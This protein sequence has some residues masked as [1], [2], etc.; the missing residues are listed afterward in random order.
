[1]STG[2]GE[3]L[4][5]TFR[6][7][8]AAEAVAEN[9]D[10][11]AIS[12]ILDRFTEDAWRQVVLFL[13]AIL[14][15]RKSVVRELR[16]IK[17]QSHPLGLA[18][19]GVAIAEGADVPK[20]FTT[21]VVQDLC[22]EVLANANHG[23]CE[24]L[25]TSGDGG[26]R[27]RS[28][29]LPFIKASE[30]SQSIGAIIRGLT[31]LAFKYGGAGSSAVHD[32]FE[33]QAL[34]ALVLI[35][36]D[37]SAPLTLR[38]EIA[39]RLCSSSRSNTGTNELRTLLSAMA[40]NSTKWPQ[41]INILSK[42]TDANL[43]ASLSEQGLVTGSRWAQLLN[44][45]T[46]NVRPSLLNELEADPGIP[47]GDK[48]IVK[49]RQIVDPEKAIEALSSS[50]CPPELSKPLFDVLEKASDASAILR[51]ATEPGF[52]A[53]LH[54]RALRSLKAIKASPE[55]LAIAVRPDL[56][57]GLRYR[58]GLAAYG[59][60]LSPS[61]VSQLL[62]FF[63]SLGPRSSR[64]DILARRGFLNYRQGSFEESVSLFDKLFNARAGTSWELGIR[65]HA[66]EH[67]GRIDEAVEGYTTANQ[68]DAN[69]SFTR[70]RLAYILWTQ[71]K[72]DAA[73]QQ[74]DEA[75]FT[76][77]TVLD[78]FRPYGGDILR[79]VG[80]LNDAE[81]WLTTTL[82]KEPVHVDALTY[83]GRVAFDKGE[84]GS[85]VEYL[86]K[87]VGLNP[88]FRYAR[89]QLARV[90]RTAGRFA[91]AAAAFADLA[92]EATGES[93]YISSRAEALLRLGSFSEANS[94]IAD[95]RSSEPDQLYYLFLEAL[96]R[97][98]QGHRRAFHE[99]SYEALRHIVTGE[100]SSGPHLSIKALFYL[101]S[102]RLEQ[103][104]SFWIRSSGRG[105]ATS[106]A[107][108]RSHFLIA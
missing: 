104:T 50:V 16:H 4:H 80:K 13:I 62:S 32:L 37:P 85:A 29:L 67:L 43:L 48:L 27:A 45:L 69:N 91:D 76:A 100:S 15:E 89:I 34:D 73:A 2:Q 57:L 83:R 59:M 23:Y 77:Y 74:I 87:A 54:L 61:A 95:L 105:Y 21:E 86:R 93:E 90:L 5:P 96:S 40:A 55:L 39:E 52:A 44:S 75:G 8:L 58:A 3:W 56:P 84:F 66:L 41:L 79:E 81:T 68:R 103:P 106:C 7:F 12:D 9:G 71:G 102:G 63:N 107:S 65:A 42:S 92:A 18:F 60:P 26:S 19:V 1:M 35:A 70:C 98:F 14:S 78:W 6:E 22:A 99:L 28:A 97:C 51:V 94:I 38:A 17:P 53:S 64:P 33:L 108:T 101:R 24:R 11:Q 49:V 47:P 88:T 10:A 72:C 82:R 46:A 36:G 20:E 25:L 31:D 30:H